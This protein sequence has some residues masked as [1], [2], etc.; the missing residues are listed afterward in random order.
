M[1]DHV[2][3]SIGQY[4][5]GELNEAD[6]R[7]VDEHIALCRMCRREYSDSQAVF[8]VLPQALEPIAPPTRILRNI[9]ATVG[10]DPP[11]RQRAPESFIWPL[12]AGLALALL[13]DAVLGFELAS[14]RN[15]PSSPQKVATLQRV[16]QAAATVTV[17]SAPAVVP[18]LVVPS[19]HTKPTIAPVPAVVPSANLSPP[20]ILPSAGHAL[21]STVPPVHVPSAVRRTPDARDREGEEIDRLRALTVQDGGRIAL[22][23]HRLALEAGRHSAREATIIAALETGRVYSVN[24][25]VGDEAWKGTVVQATASSNALLLTHAPNAPPGVTYHAWVVRNGQTYNIGAITP[26]ANTALETPMPLI[27]GDVVAFS[28][29]SGSPRQG[30][31]LP[32]LMKLPITE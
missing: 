11:Q 1:M 18:G 7:Y 8:D 9:L 30:P 16:S 23:T 26:S 20:R 32:Y 2:T 21:Q 14:T 19:V 17:H 29:E 31:T 5:L 12:A 4:L 15:Q 28:R 27:A 22:L 6:A 10:N 24:G 13:G 3:D 25:V